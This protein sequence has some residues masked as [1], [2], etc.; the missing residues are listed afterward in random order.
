[1]TDEPE[2]DDFDRAWART[3]E[4]EA[5]LLHQ[6]TQELLATGQ[7]AYARDGRTLTASISAKGDELRI[8]LD[9]SL[10]TW[11]LLIGPGLDDEYRSRVVFGQLGSGLSNL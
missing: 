5:E 7:I 10:Y 4:S 2:E 3:L 1:M 11:E 8:E 9:N 6:L